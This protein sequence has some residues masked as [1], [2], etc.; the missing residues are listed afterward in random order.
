MGWASYVA[1]R[2]LA[3]NHF[4]ATTYTLPLALT[5]FRE[6]GSAD[7]K[8]R[9]EVLSGKRAEIIYFGRRKCLRV[10]LEPMPE[11]ESAIVREFLESTADGQIFDFDPWGEAASPVRQMQVQRQDDRHSE[12]PFL[13]AGGQYDWVVFGFDLRLVE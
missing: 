7:L 6:T 9:N 1:R 8:V 13:G 12:T 11:E 5:E 2:E 10:T 3:P 4:V